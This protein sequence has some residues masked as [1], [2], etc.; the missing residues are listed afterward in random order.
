MSDADF[1][2]ILGV[3]RSASADEI[4]SAYRELVKRYHPDLFP[5]AGEKAEATEK[6]GQINEAYA[7][8]GNA[9]R[10]QRYDQRFIQVPKTR[11]SRAPAATKRRK[12][13]RPGVHANLRSKMANSLKGRLYFSKKR[14]GYALAGAMVALVLIYA[15]RSEPRLATA[16]T[17]LEKLEVTPAKSLSRP[18]GTGEGWVRLGAYASVSECAAIIKRKVR[19]DEQEGS[20]AVL[21]EQ[22]GTMAITL[23]VKKETAQARD[24]SN[25]HAKPE[26]SAGDEGAS[27]D[28]LRQLDQQ[29][30]QEGIKSIPK[31]GMIKRVRSLECRATQRVETESWLRRTLRRMGLLF[32]G[33]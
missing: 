5:L 31:S 25:F 21:D 16:W 3:R 7:V 28:E 11:R 8:L 24:D 2:Q 26:R 29:V 1:Y 19:M 17:L 4:K 30:T 33:K 6:L 9:A 32:S 22:N 15:D 27:K 14:A 23:Y 10:R 13:S 18:E 12:A 20:R